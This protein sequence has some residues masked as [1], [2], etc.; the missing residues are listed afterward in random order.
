MNTPYVNSRRGFTLIEL[1]TVIAIIGILAA[2]IIPTV[3]KVRE[4]AKTSQCTSNIRQVGFA[5]RMRA[6]ENKG[7]FPLPLL[8]NSETVRGTLISSP[9]WHQLVEVY[10][11]PKSES[12]NKG[13]NPVMSCPG[14]KWVDVDT[15]EVGASYSMAGAAMGLN[16][17]KTNNSTSVNRNLSTIKNLSMSPLLV[18][19]AQEGQGA[20]TKFYSRYY[21]TNNQVIT[22]VSSNTNQFADFR[23]GDS[24]NLCMADGSVKRI[25][26][27]DWTARYPSIGA[28]GNRLYIGVQ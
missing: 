26:R 21:V 16:A 4:T 7:M 15:S 8:N 5:L 12:W 23:H 24:M 6:E 2:I 13:H 10:L 3:G 9:T 17:A 14:V 22:D 1:L 28:N 25:K 11:P 27:S 20:A 19:G 18:E